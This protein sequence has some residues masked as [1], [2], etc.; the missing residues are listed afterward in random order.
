MNNAAYP[1]VKHVQMES[2]NVGRLNPMHPPWHVHLFMAELFAASTQRVTTTNITTVA[3]HKESISN[4]VYPLPGRLFVHVGKECRSD[5]PAI[6]DLQLDHVP[7]TQN[8]GNITTIGK[9]REL[10]LCQLALIFTA[11]TY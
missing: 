11:L 1:Y 9:V 6:L 8:S 7:G 3:D 2:A 10:V 4:V 5:Q